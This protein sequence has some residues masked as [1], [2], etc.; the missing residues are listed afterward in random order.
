[1]ETGEKK[2]WNRSAANNAPPT[3][4]GAK[5]GILFCLCVL[6]VLVGLAILCVWLLG[7]R[8]DAGM[9]RPAV[10]KPAKIADA[11]PATN[12]AAKAENSD[13]DTAKDDG[14]WHPPKN[15]YK[16]ERGVWRYP[17]GLRV[18][19]PTRPRK[20]TDLRMEGDKPSIFHYRAEKEIERLLTLEPGRPMFG[21][22]R[23]DERFEKDYLESLKEPII[24]SKDDSDEDKALKQMMIDTKIEISDRMRNGETLKGIL[25]EVRNEL[26]RMAEYKRSLQQMVVKDVK[27]GMTEQELDDYVKAANIMLEQNGIPPIKNTAILK[28]NIRL[29][30]KGNRK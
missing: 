18:Y 30:N 15:A 23:Y 24:I 28:R 12:D 22:R 20:T 29:N 9:R 27:D 7:G 5:R 8:G 2:G 11:K 16:D 4:R 6:A 17:G 19:D 1:M 14:E 25:E 21:T 10:A 26:Q 3:Q 13:A